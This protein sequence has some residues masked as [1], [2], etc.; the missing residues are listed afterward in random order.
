MEII[1]VHSAKIVEYIEPHLVFSDPELKPLF[2]EE[3]MQ[4]MMNA[5]ASVLVLAAI[6]DSKVLAFVIAQDPGY[7]VPF[8]KVAQLW[9]HPD[10]GRAITDQFF[11]KVIS[12]ALALG[13]TYIRA[14]TSRDPHA[15]Y[16]R[17]KF[18]PEMQIMRFNLD[19]DEFQDALQDH[20]VEFL[21]WA[22][23]SSQ[24]PAKSTS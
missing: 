22:T 20:A 9:S 1:R 8:V 4:L 24:E 17:F 23:S 2:V 3:L 7:R 19:S 18:K 14:E 12:W 10:N 13:K 6:E 16:R 5:P 11:V 21:Q 15:F